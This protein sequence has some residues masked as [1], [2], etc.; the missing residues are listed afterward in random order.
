MSVSTG[1]V[2]R[3]TLA[4]AVALAWLFPVM[5]MA[6]DRYVSPSGTDTG[7]CSNISAPCKTPTYC[8]GQMSAG[9][10]CNLRAGTYTAPAGG[11][12]FG[13]D[14]GCTA[15][16]PCVIRGY[17]SEVAIIKPNSVTDINGT[18]Q[19]KGGS[20]TSGSYSGGAHYLQF[21]YLTIYGKITICSSPDCS[22][23][24]YNVPQGF[25]LHH[26]TIKC[27]T[28]G[29]NYCT[30]NAHIYTQLGDSSNTE[31]RTTANDGH[32]YENLFLEDSTCDYSWHTSAC[33][34]EHSGTM[35]LYATYN[36]VIENNDFRFAAGTSVPMA[37][38]IFLKNSDGHDKIRYNYIEDNASTAAAF[39]TGYDNPSSTLT[40][41]KSGSNEFYQN[42]VNGT[43]MGI[44]YWGAPVSGSVSQGPTGT[45]VYN[46]TFFRSTGTGDYVAQH[47]DDATWTGVTSL[48]F[49]NNLS[50]G[51]WGYW[52]R[53]GNYPQLTFPIHGSSPLSSYFT[54]LNNNLYYDPA[55]STA[56]WWE[57][58]ANV[59]N[60][61]A[62]WTARLSSEY[63]T[64]PAVTENAS[65]WANPNFVNAASKNWRLQAGSPALTGGRGGSYSTV[66]GA[67]VTGT[68]NIGCT[69]SPTCNAYGGSQTSTSPSTVTGLT[70][71]DAH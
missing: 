22:G 38:A 15:A 4:A 59:G 50:M 67:Y 40:L 30:N 63:P 13:Q 21:A 1:R 36:W 12:G 32:I 41:T 35:T 24:G 3:L 71:T 61:L 44:W 46:N 25:A 5:A 57:A 48:E 51:H 65:K 10:N 28:I 18:L 47:A 37:Q 64:L 2:K 19:V 69:F 6:T 52:I 29:D 8:F 54:Y 34:F 60:T 70:R 42:V 58:G 62:A 43:Q 27:L 14:R 23:G 16:A 7:N 26:S 66:L 31:P 39:R 55:G 11:F 68:E 45:K 53:W 17:Q 33:N 20:G 49:F 9:D 56:Q